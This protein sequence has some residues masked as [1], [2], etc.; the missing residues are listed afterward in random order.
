MNR[1]VLVFALVAQV[2]GGGVAFADSRTPGKVIAG[3][4]EKITL[5]PWNLVVKAKLD[6]GAMTSSINAPDVERFD[7]DGESWVRFSLEIETVDGELKTVSVERPVVRQVRIRTAA[8]DDPERRP[9]V[10][11][12]L[13]LNGQPHRAQFTLADRGDLHYPVLLGRRFMSDVVVIDPAETFLTKATCDDPNDPRLHGD[14]PFEDE[15]HRR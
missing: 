4:V 10:E 13:C 11:L 9:V 14:P 2:V 8:A 5:K 1:R 3:Y 7:R 12:D 6:T 15:L